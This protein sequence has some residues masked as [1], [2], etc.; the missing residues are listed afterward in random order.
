M[1][2][3]AHRHIL[4]LT[5]VSVLVMALIAC[6]PIVHKTPAAEPT[7]ESGQTSLVTVVF[8][9]EIAT[10]VASPTDTVIPPTPAPPTA[11]A[12][13]PIP[14]ATLAPA[15]QPLEVV[16]RW[17]AKTAPD[18]LSFA[19]MVENPDPDLA[20]TN[21]RY[22]VFAYDEGGTQVGK[23]G[24]TI[25]LVLPG[26]RLAVAGVG[27]MVV[28]AEAQVARLEVEIE[29]GQAVAS[30]MKENPLTVGQSEFFPTTYDSSV[31]VVI[32]NSL[33][34]PIQNVKVVALAYDASS[35]Y[36]SSGVGRIDFVPAQAEAAATIR[37]ETTEEP[38][39]IDVYPSLSD[40]AA[41]AAVETSVEFEA[42]QLTG[43][44][45][46]QEYSTLFFAFVFENPNPSLAFEGNTYQV[47]AYDAAGTVLGT[48]S[49]VLPVVFPGQR[50]G[51]AGFMP[52][53][54]EAQVDKV[55]VQV[56]PGESQASGL[57][58]NPFATERV[59]F[60][61]DPVQSRVT[62]I[63]KSTLDQDVE[64]V[65]LA[66]IA[67]DEKGAI[68]G[69][70]EGRLDF[71]PAN[72]QA[73][74]SVQIR[75]LGEPASVE[76]YARLHEHSRLKEPSAQEQPLNVVA[77]G[78]LRDPNTGK[79]VITF[80]V[81]NASPR[82][83]FLNTACQ[84]AAYDEAGTVLGTSSCNLP[85]VFPGERLGR[86]ADVL[87]PEEAT[88]ARVEVQLRPEEPVE[89]QLTQNPF[90]VEGLEYV[91][92]PHGYFPQVTG[93]V[94]SSWGKDTSITLAAVAYDESGSIIGGGLANALAEANGQGT[95]SFYLP[96]TGGQPPAR[97]ELY[98]TFQT[99]ADL[100]Q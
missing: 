16:D 41:L 51:V 58:G 74:A 32:E 34:S 95:V 3:T 100:P 45:F 27:S 6:S 99:Y 40:P 48:Y 18:R 56:I 89:S 4:R 5:T 33:N 13:A 35:A 12:S 96:T 44:W 52:L 50:L 11:A 59:A 79:V 98:P 21:S 1:N 93:L 76:L 68:V 70:G 69:G 10:E 53:L 38:A 62:G 92:D 2:A 85:V 8:T 55:D 24:R 22:Q 88:I 19:F 23:T 81:E 72:G 57:S 26:Q 7:S 20:V 28:P 54:S 39:R 87:A 65:W 82:L 84:A 64:T 78:F 30:E 75:T 47:M 80:I 91:P 37:L 90:T 15:A 14:T 60:S 66:A 25:E 31:S 36:M 97:V 67:Y 61:L 83:T 46:R 77:T 9:Q 49:H 86:V 94:K 17:F 43:S 42:F 63:V 29:P 73:P 71:V